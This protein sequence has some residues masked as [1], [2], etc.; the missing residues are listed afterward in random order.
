MITEMTETNNNIHNKID[1]SNIEYRVLLVF[2]IHHN[3]N[4]IVVKIN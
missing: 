3:S 1:H 4:K 2:K